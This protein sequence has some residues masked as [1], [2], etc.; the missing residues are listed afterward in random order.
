[1]GLLDN[2]QPPGARIYP[3][4]IRDIAG[5]LEASDAKIFLAAVE[6]PD[7][8]IYGLAGELRKRGIELTPSV[9]KKHREKACSCSKI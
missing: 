4:K 8:A 9:I 5:T 1:M 6:N 2:L 3:C 7:W